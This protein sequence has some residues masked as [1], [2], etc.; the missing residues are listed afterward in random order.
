MSNALTRLC[1]THIICQYA[2]DLRYVSYMIP[3]SAE[4]GAS[5]RHGFTAS[6]AGPVGTSTCFFI[7]SRRGCKSLIGSVCVS[8]CTFG[9]IIMLAMELLIMHKRHAEQAATKSQCTRAWNYSRHC[10]MTQQLPQRSVYC[11]LH[12]RKNS[13]NSRVL[14]LSRISNSTQRKSSSPNSHSTSCSLN[15]CPL[16][17]ILTSALD[18]N[19]K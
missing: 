12:I 16:F 2:R 15:F 19:R 5:C 6:Y 9:S 17:F 4:I 7:H 1:A 13:I 8:Y 18:G 14:F 3:G 11:L 10:S